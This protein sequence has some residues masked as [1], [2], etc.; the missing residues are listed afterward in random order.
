M[1]FDVTASGDAC[2]NLANS[3][4][5]VRANITRLKNDDLNAADMVGPINNSTT[6]LPK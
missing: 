6:R 2:R 5:C 1:E 4:L 3:F